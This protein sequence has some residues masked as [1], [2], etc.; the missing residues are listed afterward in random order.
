MTVGSVV[1]LFGCAPPPTPKRLEMEPIGTVKNVPITPIADESDSGVTTPNS[2]TPVSGSSACSSSDFDNLEEALK[3]CEVPM[4]RAAEVPALKDKLDVKITTNASSTTPGGRIDVQIM[5]R[6]KTGD[7][8]ALYFTGDPVPRFDLEAVDSKG[9]RVDLPASKWPGYPKGM[10]PEPREA[11]AAKVTLD[12]N[13]TARIKVTWDAVKMKWAPERAKVWDGRGYPRTP[14][15]PLG[16][17]KYS[18]RVV[19]P[20]IGD[21]DT[22]K[23][24]VEIDKG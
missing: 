4:P 3:Q 23:V 10:K 22:P 5:L 17:G 7:P 15:G 14:A 21:I 20:L 24:P 19:L 1:L 16:P 18:L 12:K 9:R 2:G 13:G 6:N 8:L 11:K